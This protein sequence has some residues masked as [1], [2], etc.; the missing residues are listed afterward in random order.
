ME[1]RDLAIKYKTIYKEIEMILN[2]IKKTGFDI[3]EFKKTLNDIDNDINNNVKNN[4]G[5]AYLK[6]ANYEQDY[7]N[8]I[9]RLTKLKNYLDRY[10]CYFKAY[11]SCK[12]IEIKIKNKDISKEELEKYVSEMI[13]NLKII[14]ESDT[15]DYDNEKHIVDAIYRI[16]YEL[17]KLE[18][19]T[20]GKSE[21][22]LYIKNRDVNII[23]FD[24][25][26]QKDIDKLDLTD[27]K[28]IW[29]NEK[30]YENYKNGIYS[31]IFDIEVIKRLL[32]NSNGLSIKEKIIDNLNNALNE[33]DNNLKDISN[34]FLDINKNTR[35]MDLKK[36]MA[37]ESKNDVLKPLITMSLTL[38]LMI[39]GGV[40]IPKLSKKLS[41]S[42]AY[43]KKSEIYSSIDDSVK[44]SEEKLFYSN[45]PADEMIIRVYDNYEN[46]NSRKYIEY[47]VNFKKFDTLK[48]YYDYGIDNYGIVGVDKTVKSGNYEVI[49]NYQD[50]YTEVIKSTYEYLGKEFFEEAYLG[51]LVLL[52]IL[53][54]IA[55]IAAESFYSSNS[56]MDDGIIIS[57]IREILDSLPDYIEYSREYKLYNNKIKEEINKL[58]ILINENEVLKNRFYELYENNKYLLNDREELIE[59]INKL[60]NDV[61]LEKAKKLVKDKYKGK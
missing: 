51:G 11:N 26:I 24:Y 1:T 10:D 60:K 8:G 14:N 33:I 58:M 55:I 6:R 59:R 31:S 13:L 22:Y 5:V 61:R 40:G 53:Y 50:S 4:S 29:I 34:I 45:K 7:A 19:I 23:Y 12:W 54:A 2:N 36:E 17:I 39:G 42:D 18:I 21:L 16:A 43:M 38:S 49:S 15:M 32:A 3:S 37:N 25:L 44:T 56:L 57:K 52:Y 20:T 27:S 41:M 35:T 28:N 46:E 9:G 48:E 47:D 30:I